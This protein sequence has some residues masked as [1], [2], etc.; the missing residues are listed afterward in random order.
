MS[1][2]TAPRTT[3]LDLPVDLLVL[4]FP[5]LD[6]P[7]FLSLT[8]TCTALHTP[9]FTHD[10]TYWSALVRCDFRVPNQ[11]VVE[12]DGQRWHKLYKRL[13]T[14]SKAYTWGNNEKGCL[15]HAVAQP[16]TGF[17]GTAGHAL[18]RHGRRQARKAGYPGEMQG[19]ENL[20]VIAD[21]QC[22]GW[23]TTLLTAKGA[24]YTV[25]VLDGLAF[26]QR[27]PHQQ[28]A[29]D[30]PT[31][32]GFPPGY[33]QPQDDRYEP[34]TA[35]K[36]F[37]SGR[38]HVLALSDSGKIWSWQNAAHPGLHVKFVHH[39]TKEYVKKT[40]KGAVRK[41]VAGWN[42]SAALVTGTG[43]VLWEPLEL[44]PDQDA[45]ADAVLVLETCAVPN[46]ASTHVEDE[47]NSIGDVLNFI[48]LE[49][50]IVFNTTAGKAYAA[51]IRWSPQS[52]T[53]S[54]PIELPL[55]KLKDGADDVVSD[56]QGSFRNFAVF[57]KSGAVLTSTQDNV[58]P[59]LQSAPGVR[60]EFKRIPALQN[61]QVI[62][63][64]FGD[65]HFH[66]L[67]A[68]GYI[69]SYGS[70]PQL[71]GALGI[72]GYGVPESRLR[73]IRNQALGGDGRLVP[74]AYTEGR[75]IWFEEEK[76]KWA[77]FLTSGG[78]DQQEAAERVRMAI[79]SPH[80]AAQ[81]EV[82]EWIEQEARDWE[83]KFGIR[84]EDDDGLGAYFVLNVTAAGWHSGALVLVN[85]SMVEKLQKAVEVPDHLTAAEEMN[86]ADPSET[87]NGAQA[88]TG[89]D[90]NGESSSTWTD[91]A[92]D[93][94]RYFLGLAPYN[95]SSNTYDPN[96]PHLRHAP[97]ATQSFAA[98]HQLPQRS[99]YGASPRE[100]YHYIWAD[101]HFPRLR[102]S[103][104][105]EMPGNIKFHEW[106]YGR[107]E[108]NLD[109]ENPQGDDEM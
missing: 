80:V 58:M 62:S 78:V 96:A 28:M 44:E 107:P 6:A 75:R 79:G 100:G 51:L 66:A 5:Y 93:W 34:T 22:G 35:V 19:L 17:R 97:T 54:N 27:P 92:A 106:R 9:D 70:E 45:V 81:G 67:H 101:D 15:G 13:R 4:I 64:A 72:G 73:G 47:E 18:I 32:L 60:H 84:D 102:L 2:K 41:V 12:N 76:R 52:Q 31:P 82:S 23:S 74:H 39:E 37:S 71:C 89:Q 3:L 86:E 91:V 90:D 33:P 108:W 36:G 16:P 87:A 83:T 61:Q 85:E 21:M 95:V 48:V 109:W 99:D 57:T 68:P 42:K 65:Y 1:D 55:P 29:R 103:D 46:T 25:G 63:L 104:G 40:E 7:S 11:P 43:I 98:R 105:T 56:V 49:D 50:T 69:T 53:V 24:L 26:S 30:T 14:Q 8:S 88:S 94:G 77:Q 20:G 10:S 38:A 59:L